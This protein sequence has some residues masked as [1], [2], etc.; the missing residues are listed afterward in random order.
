M[1]RERLCDAGPAVKQHWVGVSCLL[2]L[3]RTACGIYDVLWATVC[4]VGPT[5]KT[6]SFPGVIY[7]LF[8]HPHN[9]LDVSIQNGCCCPSIMFVVYNN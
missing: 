8:F 5:L 2:G 4:D 9:I 1:V 6:V 3:G 7:I